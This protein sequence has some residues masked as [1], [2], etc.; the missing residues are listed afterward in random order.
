MS[1]ITDTSRVRSATGQLRDVEAAHVDEEIMQR[2]TGLI[3]FG[4]GLLNSL[5][6]TRFLF[7]MMDANPANPFAQFIYSTTGPLLST[8]RGLVQVVSVNGSVFEFQDLIAIAVYAMLGWSTAH[9]IR[10]LFTRVR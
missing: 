1:Q 4:V 8:F 9:L 2:V 5:I 7:K 10:I 3:L 6:L